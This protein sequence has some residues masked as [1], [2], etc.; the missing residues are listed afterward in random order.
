MP[1]LTTAADNPLSLCGG[2]GG[3]RSTR[4]PAFYRSYNLFPPLNLAPLR[5]SIPRFR[6]AFGASN[7]FEDSRSAE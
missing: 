6:A 3:V 2:G 1:H 5:V 7:S 4:K